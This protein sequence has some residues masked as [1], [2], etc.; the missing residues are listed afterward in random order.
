M[1][2]KINRYLAEVARLKKTPHEIALGFAIGVFIGILPTPGFNILF[3][4]LVI[5]IFKNV[6]KLA[7]F[8]GMAVF[9]PLTSSYFIY[10]SFLIGSKIVKPLA[11]RD[12]LYPFITQFLHTSL[13]VLVGSLI[14]GFVLSII[15]YYVVKAI[16]KKM[17]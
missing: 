16:V 7:L 4:M 9:N 12:A 13:M 1:K 14:I 15:S 5:F 17:K 10:L 11:P 6:N 2:V 3:G 8:G